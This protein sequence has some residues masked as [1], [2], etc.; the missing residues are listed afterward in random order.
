M[1]I[2]IE[3]TI[4]RSICHVRVAAIMWVMKTFIIQYSISIEL[5]RSHNA[6]T[7]ALAPPPPTW[8]RV[9]HIYVYSPEQVSSSIM[10]R[11]RH[12]TKKNDS[13]F[14]MLWSWTKPTTLLGWEKQNWRRKWIAF[15]LMINKIAKVDHVV[16]Q[17][18]TKYSICISCKIIMRF[19]SREN[20]KI[21]VKI[22]THRIQSYRSCRRKRISR[23]W[24]RPMGEL[25][26]TPSC[27]MSFWRV[28]VCVWSACVY[29]IEWT[30]LT[31]FGL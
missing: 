15:I 8:K 21:A 17:T 7:I 28:A 30:D 23:K 24:N 26:H 1:R 27:F 13:F 3:N 4:F 18:K 10:I 2:K 25:L 16:R 14:E 9:I 29:V 12:R 5:L 20:G 19:C 6:S 11:L 31:W 22:P